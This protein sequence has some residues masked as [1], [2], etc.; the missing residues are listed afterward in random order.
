MKINLHCHTNYSDGDYIDKMAEEYQKQGFSA[1]V[2]TD[3]V[4]PLHF[5]TDVRQKHP[6]SI[7]SYEKF[8][9]QTQQLAEIEQNLSFPC[10]QG[11]ELALYGEEVLVFGKQAVKEIFDFMEHINIEEQ[12]KYIQEITYKKKIVTKL[13]NILEKNKDETAVILCH[14][15]LVDDDWVLKK[16]YP[17]L[18]GYEFQ[19]GNTYYFTDATNQNEEQ[20]WDREI[21]DELKTKKKFYNSDAHSIRSITQSEGNFHTLKICNLDDLISYIKSPHGENINSNLLLS[22]KCKG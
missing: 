1:F 8:K 16:L 11:I 9:Q 5:A 12:E 13:I 21:P 4:Y 19:N 14:P 7:I 2:A 17:I 6:K 3:H 18:D 15:H 10:I 20:R 22:Q